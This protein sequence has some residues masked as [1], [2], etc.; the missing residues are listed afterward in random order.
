MRSIKKFIFAICL[1]VVGVSLILFGIIFPQKK[2]GGA[3]K[4]S[5]EKE[6]DTKHVTYEFEIKTKEAIDVN[7]VFMCLADEKFKLNY[8]AEISH[9]EYEF[10][11]T[12]YGWE[13][14]TAAGGIVLEA[15]NLSGEK[16]EF[17]EDSL[18]NEGLEIICSVLPIS[19]G[20]VFFAVGVASMFVSKKNK[21]DEKCQN[22]ENGILGRKEA[23]D[24]EA[25]EVVHCEY[26]GCTVSIGQRK[27]KECGAPL[28]N[29][30]A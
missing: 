3:N 27:C 13:Y 4:F 19:F 21:R 7:N 16:I 5:Y 20:G 8:E 1:I 14:V 29:K 22:K 17:V 26:C 9:H 30:K 11:L 23:V 24:G 28:K 15:Y 12:L 18:F 2:L 10:E 25:L 6:F